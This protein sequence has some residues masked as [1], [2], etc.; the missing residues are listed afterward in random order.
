M[1]QHLELLGHKVK[2]PISGLEG[3]VTS[4]CF[5]INGC[6]QG[7]VTPPVDKD[8]K[9]VSGTWVDIQRLEKVSTKTLVKVSDFTHQTGAAEKPGFNSN[10]SK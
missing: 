3:V 7:A 8:G 9:V 2:D 5:D 1:K 10:P 4:I 6:I